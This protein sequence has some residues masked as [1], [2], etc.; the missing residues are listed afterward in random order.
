MSRVLDE[1]RLEPHCCRSCFGRIASKA[2][3]D[4]DDK[5]LYQCTHCGLEAEGHKAAVLCACGTKLPK[6]KGKTVSAGLQCHENKARSIEFPAVIVASFAG[7][8]PEA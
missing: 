7:A 4:E 5:R 3:D 2:L 6:G 8:Q 1:W